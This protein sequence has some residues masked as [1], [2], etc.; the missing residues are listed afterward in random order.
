VKKIVLSALL[1]VL[2]CM[3]GAQPEKK[4]PVTVTP[5]VDKTAIW[6][7]DDVRYTIR[8]VHDANV[9]MVLDNFTKERL[10]LA[11]FVIRDID[12]QRKEWAGD[13]G[14]VEITLLLTTFETGKPEL[15]IPLIPIYYFVR[16]PGQSEKER[17]VDS[18]PA[19]AMPIGLR[20]ALVTE[21]LIPRTAKP[22]ASPGFALAFA[23]LGLGLVGLL[24]LGAYGGW[25]AW[26]KYH[27]NETSG[28]LTREA[29]E[30]I[31][32]DSLARLRN[33][34]ATSGDDPRQWSSAIASALRA[35]VGELLQIPAA[36]QT[37]EEIEASLKQSGT[38]ASLTGQTK[39]VL[40]QC[41]ELRYG[42]GGGGPALRA[43]LVQAAERVMQSPRWIS[44]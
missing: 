42:R 10:P 37:P 6:V 3:A 4:L 17:P 32:R 26:E 8:A 19:P 40:V 35:M 16:E 20:S 44:A 34:V 29:R 23:P 39:T 14:A 13:K 43:Q 38:D 18:V 28:Q 1:L 5:Q 25:R 27:P 15:T 11:P 36:A 22:P 21:S 41:D 24:S 30:K 9:E 7:G 33:D 31:V 2:P 12:I